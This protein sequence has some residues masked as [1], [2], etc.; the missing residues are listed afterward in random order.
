MKKKK[1]IVEYELVADDYSRN[2]SLILLLETRKTTGGNPV[3][4]G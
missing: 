1:G 4:R 3:R 2:G